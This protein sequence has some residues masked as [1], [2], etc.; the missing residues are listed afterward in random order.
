MIT[1]YKRGRTW[2]ANSSVAGERR[3]WS[4][5]TRNADVAERLR[6]QAEVD[7][8]S[9]GRLTRKTWPEFEAEFLSWV[10]PQV[11]PKTLKEY[12]FTARKF[13]EFCAWHRLA[14]LA[15]VSPSFLARYVDARRMELHP[16]RKRPMAEGGV[17]AELRNLH[18]IFAYA[19]D[20]GYIGKNPVIARNLNADAGKTMPFS[21]AEIQ[22]MLAD[23]EVQGCAFLR[24]VLSVFLHTGLRI[25]DVRD[26]RKDCIHGDRIILTPRK[27]RRRGRAVILPVPPAL[28]AALDEHLRA[29]NAAQRVSPLVFSTASGLPMKNMDKRLGRVWKRVMV[30][31]A[32][33]HRFRDTFAVNLLLRG[34]SLYDV[35]KLMG[36]SVQTAERHYA[37][38][39]PELQQR[40]ASIV[41]KLDFS[42]SPICNATSSEDGTFCPQSE[43][44]R[45]RARAEK[46]HVN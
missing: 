27:T 19:L 31:H 45:P 16:S 4:L 18:R 32:H 40:A 22:R 15:H 30:P 46:S 7:I 23:A 11:A 14:A 37:P 12:S 3:Q 2:W 44:M 20:C 33:A 43:K 26:L 5:R 34:A 42:L 41:D 38:Y 24:A 13:R 35:A 29:Q 39:V 25:S 6:R 8:L 10:A 36:I 28:R 17:R 1:L 9:G 21:A